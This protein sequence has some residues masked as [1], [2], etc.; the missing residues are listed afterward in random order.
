MPSGPFIT[1]LKEGRA[2]HYLGRGLKDPE[3]AILFKNL[4]TR[5]A[6]ARPASSC[7]MILLRR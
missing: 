3:L 5:Y 6:A 1:I 4:A 2:I 7:C